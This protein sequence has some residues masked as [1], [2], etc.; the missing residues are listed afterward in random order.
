LT[1]AGSPPAVDAVPH[2]SI[3]VLAYNEAGSLGRVVV[4][5]DTALAAYS[6]EIVIVDDGSAD[7]TPSI[8][9][10]LAA[11][12]PHVR[13]VHHPVNR[14]GGAAT[15]TGLA[16]ARGDL[17]VVIPGDGQFAAEDLPRFIEASRHA[18]IVVGCRRNRTGGVR[19]RVSSAGYRVAIWATLGLRVHDLNWVKMYRRTQVQA[20]PLTADSWLIDAEI[21]FRL[22][23]AG[24]SITEIDVAEMPRTSGVPSGTQPLQMLAVAR[25]LWR[26][27]RHLTTAQPAYRNAVGP[28]R[29][30][31]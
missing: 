28:S 1:E 11:A 6:H 26:F 4:D 8:A 7:E 17:V 25:E 27:R 18:D 12:Q 16:S 10:A 15:R 19:R 14:G 30:R 9:D 24:R 22:T 13:V 31:T 20:L 3:A 21:L 23:R 5:V 2:I 29:G